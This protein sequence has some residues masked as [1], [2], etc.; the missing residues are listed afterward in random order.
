G[1]ITWPFARLAFAYVAVTNST[2]ET[3]ILG[4][5]SPMDYC[6]L[7][8]G[9]SGWSPAPFGSPFGDAQLPKLLPGEGFMLGAAIPR[10]TP[11]KVEVSYLNDRLSSRIWQKL[12]SWLKKKLWWASPWRTA[13]TEVIDLSRL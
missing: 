10:D 1:D 9:K 8:K 12:P 2:S 11:C 7:V 3:L 6:M 4:S 13:T 5:G